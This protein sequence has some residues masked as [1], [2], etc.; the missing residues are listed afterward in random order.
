MKYFRA[1][2]IDNLHP[3]ASELSG[4][5]KDITGEEI[6]GLLDLMGILFSERNIDLITS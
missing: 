2:I 5:D 4:F 3:S 6:V 1:D